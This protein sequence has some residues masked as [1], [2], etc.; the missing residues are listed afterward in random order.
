MDYEK[1]ADVSDL[2]LQ[3]IHDI[4]LID[5]FAGYTKNSYTLSVIKIFLINKYGL[6]FYRKNRTFI[7]FTIT[8]FYNIYMCLNYIW[9]VR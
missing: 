5:G 3:F 8:H 4:D 7:E 1:L 2:V 6:T 9:T